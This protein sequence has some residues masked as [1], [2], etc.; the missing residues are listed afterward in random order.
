MSKRLNFIKMNEWY[1]KIPGMQVNNNDQ[2]Q[3]SGEQ[4]QYIYTI[5]K[6]STDFNPDEIVLNFVW[7]AYF[8]NNKTWTR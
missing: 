8:T 2:Q 6:I 7:T 5:Y 4:I 1:T 3:I